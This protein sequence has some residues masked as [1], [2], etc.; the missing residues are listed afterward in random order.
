MADVQPAH[1]RQRR[2]I[3]HLPQQLLIF[4]LP[5][6]VLAMLYL[7]PHYLTWRKMV[8][9]REG[10]ALNR[11]LGFT[12]RNMLLMG[13]LITLALLIEKREIISTLL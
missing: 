2:I 7:L 8:E 12:S 9:I 1:D 6:A 13:I 11:I 4:R 3:D 10:R 5:Y